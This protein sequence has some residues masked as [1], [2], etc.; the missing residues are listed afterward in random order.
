MH[1]KNAE[2]DG[3]RNLSGQVSFAHPLSVL[4]GPN[5]AGKSNVIDALRMTLTPHSGWPLKVSRED[6][7]HSG[8]GTPATE[9][10]TVSLNFANLGIEQSARMLTALDG[11][12]TASLHTA[13]E[14]PLTGR[15]KSR[16]LGGRD[17]SANLEEWARTAVTY[18]YLKPLRDAELDMRPGRHNYIVDLI[19]A[20]AGDGDD[21]QAVV[22]IAEQANIDLRE[23][24]AVS[25]SA[26]LIQ[27][28]LN[29]ISGD[30]LKQSAALLFADPAFENVLSNLG[31][32]IGRDAALPMKQNGLGLNNILYMAVVLAGLTYEHDSE[33]H[34]L[35]IEE[36]E[37]HLHPQLQDLLMRF[38]K[39]E[40]EDR[41]DVQVIVTTHS[42]NIT[43]AVGVEQITTLARYAGKL[44]TGLIDEFG[45]ETQEVN[46]LNRFLDVTKAA[47]LFANAVILVEGLAEQLLFPLLAAELGPE[48]DLAECGVTVVNVGGLA[49]G[50]FAALFDD[51]RLPN[52]CSIVS[53][54]DPP[55]EESGDPAESEAA[56]SKL[57]EPDSVLSATAQ[58]LKES[59]N[60]QRK[61][62]LAS[63]TFE[64][65][66]VLAGN[67]EWA[68]R[69]LVLLKPRVAKRLRDDENLEEG[70]SQ[71]QAVL[72]A[73][74]NRKGRFAQALT[75]TAASVKADGFTIGVP[76]YIKEAI[77]WASTSDLEAKGSTQSSGNDE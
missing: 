5:N 36:P 13:C 34:V 45:L 19:S 59:E 53:D 46:H 29:S 20:V 1:L 32:G 26:E 3:F 54:S 76:R 11:R 14:L 57:I 22:D 39:K 31:I 67:W 37:A 43:S 4:V 41:P 2:F 56:E 7:C 70:N 75:Q 65:D 47:L 72:D 10:F 58:I 71:A 24:E 15:P 8:T 51:G 6:F 69:A 62:F 60:G 68:L 16:L 21:R 49:F 33:L 50:P 63:N 30:R 48:Y 9:Q 66:L 73:I 64:Y 40:V 74:S 77:L 52:R 28:R 38:L 35:L 23:V 27:G 12:D 25:R 42:P 18:T 17:K 61:V 55:K 44:S